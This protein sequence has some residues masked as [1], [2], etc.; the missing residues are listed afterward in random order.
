MHSTNNRCWLRGCSC[1]RNIVTRCCK[2]PSMFCKVYYINMSNKF[3]ILFIQLCIR[4]MLL[5]QL[6]G[7]QNPISWRYLWFP[8]FFL[9]CRYL[10][11][12][13]FYCSRLLSFIVGSF[14]WLYSFG[15]KMCLFLWLNCLTNR[16]L[17]H[18]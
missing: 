18:F 14:N 13:Y 10:M 3:G 6:L 16:L 11:E 17:K 12:R 15:L 8:S 5:G 2:L 4:P 9:L 7:C 1:S